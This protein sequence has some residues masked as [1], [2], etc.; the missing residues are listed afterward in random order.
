MVLKESGVTIRLI[1]TPG[2]TADHLIAHLEEDNVIF[3]GDCILGNDNDDNDD[4]D[5]NYNFNTNR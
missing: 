5:I 4:N 1:P 2:H 3:S